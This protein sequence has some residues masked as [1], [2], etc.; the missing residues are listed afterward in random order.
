[1]KTDNGSTPN[2]RKEFGGSFKPD[3]SNVVSEKAPVRFS[4][5]Q[6]SFKNKKK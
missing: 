6:D 3:N 4:A 1:M 5:K 2:P